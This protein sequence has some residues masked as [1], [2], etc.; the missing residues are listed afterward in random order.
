MQDELNQTRCMKFICAVGIAFFIFCL[1][2]V[3]MG[4][5]RIV[6]GGRDH[7]YNIAHDSSRVAVISASFPLLVGFL[8]D[9]GL[10][11]RLTYPRALLLIAVIV[12]N[13]SILLSSS[14]NNTP[15]EISVCF[16]CGS[17]QL[18]V[19]GLLAFIAGE[20]TSERL[21]GLLA[22]MAVLGGTI[23]LYFVM[24]DFETS[25][26]LPPDGVLALIMF[27]TFVVL[28][29]WVITWFLKDFKS[30]DSRRK[31]FASTYIFTTFLYNILQ[32]ILFIVFD[33]LGRKDLLQD[34]ALLIQALC[35][36]GVSIVTS[37]MAQHDAIT[38][39][40]SIPIDDAHPVPSLYNPH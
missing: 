14:P 4:S 36:T 17:D 26:Q 32:V 38:A 24:A 8:Y 21:L 10:P 19:A 35:M 29:V 20:A 6:N 28:F 18:F 31:K 30:F 16:K 3:A 25:V 23:N 11:K 33:A 13:M 15:I 1:Y 12:P 34:S 22:F 9:L 27:L 2:P 40:A 37:Q 39:M 5:S 7:I